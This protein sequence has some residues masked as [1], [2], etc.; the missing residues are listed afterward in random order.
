MFDEGGP[1]FWELARQALSSTERGYD[2]LAPKFERTPFRTPDAILEA[3]LADVHG[4]L[5]AGLDLCCGTGAALPLLSERCERV[6][7]VDFSAGMLAV[8]RER[9]PN[10]E[11]RQLDVFA[12]EEPAA[13]DVVTCFGAFGH[14]RPHEEEAFVDVVYRALRPGGR[15][16]FA[17]AEMPAK[18]SPAFLLSKAFTAAMHVRNALYRHR[19]VMFYLTFMLPDCVRLLERRGFEVST[20]ASELGGPLSGLVIVSARRSPV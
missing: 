2:L 12:F 6:V 9:S 5:E 3:V 8:A 17:S 16:V 15:F 1:T 7:G 18:L 11:L 19:F 14:I 13:F 10:A 20:R 4:P